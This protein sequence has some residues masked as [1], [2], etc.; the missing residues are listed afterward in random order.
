MP[1]IK[2]SASTYCA[3]LVAIILSLSE[4]MSSYSYCKEKKLVYVTIIA[5]S[6]YQPSF[7][8]KYTKL[9]MRLFYNIRLVFNTKYL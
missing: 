9:N 4:I 2:S 3:K 8:V 7:C 6:S 5:L 1:F